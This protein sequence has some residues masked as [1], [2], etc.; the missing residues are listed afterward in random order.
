[1]LLHIITPLKQYLFL[2]QN[3][4]NQHVMSPLGVRFFLLIHGKL[5]NEMLQMDLW[6]EDGEIT[7]KKIPNI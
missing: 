7:W 2:K 3:E 1:M 5:Q 4:K 6:F